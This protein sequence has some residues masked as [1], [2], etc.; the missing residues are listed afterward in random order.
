MLDRI[1]QASIIALCLTLAVSIGIITPTL[2]GT[3]Q[4]T[5]ETAGETKRAATAIAD[6]A[7]FQTEEFKSER[8]QRSLKASVDT[9][10]YANSVMRS[11]NVRVIPELVAVLKGLQG[12]SAKLGALT[13]SLDD[14]VRH[15]DA[16]INSST[17]LLPTLTTLVASLKTIAEKTGLTVDEVKEAVRIASDKIGLSL[18]AMYALMNDPAWLQT[19]KN[20]ETTT[21]G[22]A[23]VMSNVSEA[24]KQLPS[25][26]QSLEKIA[27]TSSKYQKL[28]LAASIIGTLATAFLRR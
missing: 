5:Q 24:S 4:K 16:S 22:S 14:L 15:S 10:A 3:L 8:Y 17:G 13:V 20:I 12:N 21:A 9:G 2:R 26:A 6:W 25:I 19:L 1:K 18:D 27:K 7:E 11:I 23:A 28:L